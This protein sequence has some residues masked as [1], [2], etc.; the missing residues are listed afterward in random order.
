MCV[1]ILRTHTY[2][3]IAREISTHDTLGGRSSRI[4]FFIHNRAAGGRARASWHAGEVRPIRSVQTLTNAETSARVRAW[5]R[6]HVTHITT[7]NSRAC[8]GYAHRSR[9]PGCQ[10]SHHLVCLLVPLRPC[11]PHTYTN[12]GHSHGWPLPRADSRRPQNRPPQSPRHIQSFTTTQ[13]DER[14]AKTS[15]KAPNMHVPCVSFAPPAPCAP[16]SHSLSSDH[17]APR[18]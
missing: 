3:I 1:Y 4:T 7:H 10:T 9:S 5:A 2:D 11:R 13:H 6:P 12:R 16:P 18:A 15:L 17:R 14:H 8:T